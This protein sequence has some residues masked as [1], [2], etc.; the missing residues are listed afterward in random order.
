[1]DV[2]NT[3]SHREDGGGEVGEEVGVESKFVKRNVDKLYLPAGVAMQFNSYKHYNIHMPLLL[4]LLHKL[5]P[6]GAYR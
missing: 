3:K 2:S 4:T 5:A 1:M 6:H